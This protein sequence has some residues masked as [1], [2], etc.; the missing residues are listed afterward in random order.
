MV[1]ANAGFHGAGRR[2][3]ELGTA[4]T[5]QGFDSTFGVNYLAHVLFIEKLVPQLLRSERPV[6]VQVSSLM[7]FVANP[8]QPRQFWTELFRRRPPSSAPTTATG[9]A[10]GW[11][12]IWHRYQTYARSKLAQILYNRAAGRRYPSVRFAASCP[13]WVATNISRG[14]AAAHAILRAVAFDA[15]EWGISSVLHALLDASGG[16][17]GGG[18]S[19]SAREEA[20]AGDYYVNSIVTDLF[21]R[22]LYDDGVVSSRAPLALLLARGWVSELVGTFAGCLSLVFQKLGAASTFVAPTSALSY[23][24]TLQDEVYNWSLAAVADW[25]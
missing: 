6:V 8:Q 3:S 4:L 5:E 20:A 24:A 22:R 15:A 16:G 21:M 23:N 25:L 1:L 19:P 13:G 2:R 18:G 9:R 7:H 14:H 11:R 17:Q 12:R 10:S